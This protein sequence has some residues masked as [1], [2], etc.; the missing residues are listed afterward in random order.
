MPTH[1]TVWRICRDVYNHRRAARRAVAVAN[2]GLTRYPAR[3][4]QAPESTQH[5][6]YLLSHDVSLTEEQ[7]RSAS[8]E[9]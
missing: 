8:I 7:H 6:Q 5:W 4:K 3:P 9:I 2:T 1:R